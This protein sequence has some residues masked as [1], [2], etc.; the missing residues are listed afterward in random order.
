[1][2]EVKRLLNSISSKKKLKVEYKS[3]LE[4]I[5]N[6]QRINGMHAKFDLLNKCIGKSIT[7]IM[8]PYPSLEE[9]ENFAK[10]IVKEVAADVY[11]TD[12]YKKIVN[13]SFKET[14]AKF[15]EYKR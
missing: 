7:S 3:I 12:Y 15:M 14:L 2:E 8:Y 11:I 5:E 10:A 6:E 4:E 13:N 9:A 1:M